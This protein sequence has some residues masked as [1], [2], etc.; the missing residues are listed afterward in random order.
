ML[1]VLLKVNEAL[2]KLDTLSKLKLHSI[3]QPIQQGQLQDMALLCQNTP[4]LLL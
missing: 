3:E 2:K 1:M 4:F